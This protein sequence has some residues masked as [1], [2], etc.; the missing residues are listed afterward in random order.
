MSEIARFSVSVEDELLDEFDDYCRRQ[1]I[2]T[3]SEAV[4]QLIREK[5]GFRDQWVGTIIDTSSSVAVRLVPA[6]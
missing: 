4:R 6:S 2:A 3:R 1:Q 5:Y